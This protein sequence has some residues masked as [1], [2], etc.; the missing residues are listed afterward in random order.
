MGTKK[1]IVRCPNCNQ[2][3]KVKITLTS[4]INTVSPCHACGKRFGL[5]GQLE[6]YNP[7]GGPEK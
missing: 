5:P 7:L 3:V 1:R 2:V 6:E 4:F